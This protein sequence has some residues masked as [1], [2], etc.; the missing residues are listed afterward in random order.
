VIDY[1]TRTIKK[2]ITEDQTLQF[3]VCD[4]C[5]LRVQ[6]A[7]YEMPDHWV[8]ITIPTNKYDAMEYDV[9]DDC[10]TETLEKLVDR[11]GIGSVKKNAR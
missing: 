2:S 11:A 9:C 5:K 8:R 10:Q 3:R 1:E 7:D 6:L 4:F